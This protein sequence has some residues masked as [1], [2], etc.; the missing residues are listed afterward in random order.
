MRKR[1]LKVHKVGRMVF[2]DL[3]ELKEFIKT[4]VAR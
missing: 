4:Q 2:I 3:D 1:G